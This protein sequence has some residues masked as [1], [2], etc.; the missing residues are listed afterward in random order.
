MQGNESFKPKGA[1]AFFVAV[2][3]V[4]SVVFLTLY[5]ILVSRGSTT[6]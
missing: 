4:Y 2:A 5:A 6:P 3:V 1:I